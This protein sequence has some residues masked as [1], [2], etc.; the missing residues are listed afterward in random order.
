[1]MAGPRQFFP[2]RRNERL[3]THVPLPYMTLS[4]FYLPRKEKRQSFLPECSYSESHI[5]R[6]LTSCPL[7]CR[8]SSFLKESYPTTSFADLH[9]FSLSSLKQVTN[10]VPAK[11]VRAAPPFFHGAVN[12]IPIIFAFLTF[13]LLLCVLRFLSARLGP[14]VDPLLLLF[15]PLWQTRG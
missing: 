12:T 5:S 10:D 2:P 4:F 9:V 1:M 15:S 6:R 3:S 13:G 11:S 8:Q 7:S 14:R